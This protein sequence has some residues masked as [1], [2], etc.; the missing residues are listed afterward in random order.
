M[1]KGKRSYLEMA[2][3]QV[4]LKST[5]VSRYPFQL[6]ASLNLPI[7]RVNDQVFTKLPN[8]KIFDSQEQLIVYLPNSL[9]I[10][11]GWLLEKA[12]QES[13]LD[14]F[15]SIGSL[16]T[17]LI[18]KIFYCHWGLETKVEE[19]DQWGLIICKF[20]GIFPLLHSLHL[21]WSVVLIWFDLNC[22]LVCFFF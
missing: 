3:P 13:F 16:M 14:S 21:G 6:C 2:W 18:A 19:T 17:W 5:H 1:K 11:K 15:F 12:V 10:G 4:P 20:Q 8:S 22:F 9:L 7:F